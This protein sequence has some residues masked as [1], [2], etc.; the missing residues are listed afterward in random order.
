MGVEGDG[1]KGRRRGSNREVGGRNRRATTLD[2]EEAVHKAG[3]R[4][5]LHK[6]VAG[7][8]EGSGLMVG[9]SVAEYFCFPLLF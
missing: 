9:A 8:A 7:V 4:Q 3:Q 6:S 2:T 1:E 5:H